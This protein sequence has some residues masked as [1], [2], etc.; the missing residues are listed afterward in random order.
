MRTSICLLPIVLT[1]IGGCQ[2]QQPTGDGTPILARVGNNTISAKDLEARVAFL[3]RSKY[4]FEQYS[5]PEKKKELLTSLVESEALFQEACRLGYDR[6]PAVK[7]EVVNRMLQS[8]VEG[9][10][11]IENVSDGEIEKYYQAHPS[12][13]SKPDQ[14]RVSQIVV[15]DRAKALKVV[16]EAKA[17]PKGNTEALRIL[18]GKV[19]EDEA[20]RARGG[21]VGLIDSNV[22]TL[23]KAVVA[24]AFALK[25]AFDVSDPIQTEHGY[26]VVVLTQKQ[27]GFSK[28]LAD[29]RS[30]IQSRLFYELKQQKRAALTAEI[31]QRAKIQID[32][33][34]LA[35]L[36][37]PM[38]GS[39]TAATTS[40]DRRGLAP[41]APAPIPAPGG[42]PPSAPTPTGR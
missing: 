27:P 22:T 20:S 3:G 9:Q 16:A 31:R 39:G 8:E 1:L 10:V 4:L 5:K 32:E 26:T 23:P 40:V 15:K 29:A 17:L 14:V 33:A 7:R 36:K 18:V 34:Q 24:A 19:S 6:D 41:G 21:D 11:K 13:F 35:N 38:S 37:L 30:S 25:Q 28:S 2:K 42:P 12:E